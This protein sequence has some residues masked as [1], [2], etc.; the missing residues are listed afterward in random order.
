MTTICEFRSVLL[1][2]EKFSVY[3]NTK[4]GE[5]VINELSETLLRRIV[6]HEDLIRWGIRRSTYSGPNPSQFLHDGF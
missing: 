1:N 4:G 3:R 5:G 2:F 6:L